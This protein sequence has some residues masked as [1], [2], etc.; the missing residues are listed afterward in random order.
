MIY[1]VSHL[2]VNLGW[3]N[4]E[5]ESS[6]VCQVLLGLMRI[7]QKCLASLARWLN[8]QVKVNPTQVHEQMRHHALVKGPNQ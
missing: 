3:V 8:K 7:C 6:T 1:R 2:L 5:F 4:S